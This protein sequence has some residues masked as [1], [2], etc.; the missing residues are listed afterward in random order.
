MVIQANNPCNPFVFNVNCTEIAPGY[1]LSVFFHINQPLQL[2]NMNAGSAL[3]SKQFRT[4]AYEIA[5]VE[6]AQAIPFERLEMGEEMDAPEAL[7][8]VRDTIDRISRKFA[9][10]MRD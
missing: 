4:I 8:S 9:E 3:E 1:D 7:F 5:G 6:Y 10:A 2:L